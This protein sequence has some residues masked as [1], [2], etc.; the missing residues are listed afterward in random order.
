LRGSMSSKLLGI[1]LTIFI[2]FSAT[3]TSNANAGLIVPDIDPTSDDIWEYIGS[4]DLRDGPNWQL[5]EL[6][7]GVETLVDVRPLN[8]LEAAVFALPGLNLNIDDLAISMIANTVFH[9]AWYDRYENGVT[10]LSENISADFGNDGK[11][12]QF[13]DVSAYIS[14]HDNQESSNINYVFRRVIDVPEPSTLAIFALALIGLS[15]RRLK[16]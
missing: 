6:V 5:T 15:A 14:D 3:I 7:N 1:A 13:G 8:A 16:S 12:S 9:N 4:Y 2:L 10:V 11:Y